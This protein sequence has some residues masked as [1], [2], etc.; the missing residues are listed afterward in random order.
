MER[1]YKDDQMKFKFIKSALTATVFMGLCLTANAGLISGAHTT[2]DGKVVDLQGLEWMSLDYTAGLSRNDIEDGFTDRYGT[3]WEA[4]EW[5]YATR[6]QTEA[7]LGSLWGGVY[8][9]FSADN[10]DGAEWFISTFEGIAFDLYTGPDRVN[11]TSTDST[12]N[13]LDGAWFLFGTDG[14]CSSTVTQSCVGNVEHTDGTFQDTYG[15]NV[16]T[17]GSEVNLASPDTALGF[18]GEEHGANM[19]LFTDNFAIDKSQERANFGSLLVRSTAVPEPSTL[20]IFALG[21]M[22]I[23]LRRLNKKS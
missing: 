10:A 14:E 8:D 21:M 22:G 12:W 9:G 2:V 20:V 7:L 4:G 1:D 19:G 6:A 23:A 13:G 16:N 11:L 5:T 15:Y 17:F 18:F 3:T